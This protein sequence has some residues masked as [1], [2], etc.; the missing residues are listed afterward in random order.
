[1]KR[2][3][4]VEWRLISLALEGQRSVVV[5]DL[6][7]FTTRNQLEDAARARREHQALNV[8]MT[9]VAQRLMPSRAGK[10]SSQT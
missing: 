8:L 9:K 3:T 5:D 4:R 1:M 7:T 6:E 2:I 10:P